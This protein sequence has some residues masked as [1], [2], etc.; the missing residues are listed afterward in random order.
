MSAT[1]DTLGIKQMSKQRATIVLFVIGL[2][3]GA[4]CMV[5]KVG[6]VFAY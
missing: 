2:A 5:G 6:I 3:L 4:M 1:M